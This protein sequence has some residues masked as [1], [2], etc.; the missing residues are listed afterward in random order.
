MFFWICPL[1]IHNIEF[2]MKPYISEASQDFQLNSIYELQTFS[3]TATA[4][5]WLINNGTHE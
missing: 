5:W 4:F 2:E 1:H 3:Y